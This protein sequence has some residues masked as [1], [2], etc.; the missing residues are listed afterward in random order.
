MDSMTTIIN[1]FVDAYFFCKLTNL[2]SMAHKT[3]YPTRIIFESQK[4]SLDFPGIVCLPKALN[5]KDIFH[6]D[7][8]SK[9]FYI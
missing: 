1:I 8:G 7:Q 6:N 9:A 3:S 5:R 2:L 4:G